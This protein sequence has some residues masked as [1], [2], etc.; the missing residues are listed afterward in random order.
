MPA[1]QLSATFAALADPTRRAIL[2]R[3]AEGATSVSELAA[4]HDMSLPA[5][6]K[7]LRVLERSGLIERGRQAQWRPCALK[8]V[9]MKEAVDWLGRYR[10]HWEESLDRLGAYLEQLQARNPRSAKKPVR[11]SARRRTNR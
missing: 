7:H 5:I 2:A 1:D 10:L 6:S 11:L 3:L 4:P 9:P 8:A